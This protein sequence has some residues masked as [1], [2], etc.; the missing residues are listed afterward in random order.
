MR[1]LFFMAL[2]SVL[3]HSAFAEE[4]YPGY[5]WQALGSDIYLHAQN[6]PLAGPVDGNSVVIVNDDGVL[7][8]DTHINPAVARAVIGKI[9]SVTDAPVTHV[10]NTHWHDDH[11]NGNH[12]YR[13]TF[14]EVK[15][16]AHKDTLSSLKSQWAAMEDQRRAAYAEV[17]VEEL[18]RIA[19]R[20]DPEDPDSV[21]SYR[22]YAG[23]ITALRPELPNLRLEY[24]DVV[25]E[26][27]LPIEFSNRR[28]ELRWVGRGNTDG[29]IVVWLPGERILITGD[30][31]VAPIPFAFDS[32][33]VEWGATLRRLAEMQPRVLVP[34]HGTAQYDSYYLASVTALIEATTQRVKRAR[35]NGVTFEELNE[36]VDL[37]DFRS[38]F[39]GEDAERLW[40][41]KSYFVRP[42]VKSAWTSLGYPLP[43]E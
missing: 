1:R 40:A 9:R 5:V 32:P 37:A 16:M 36:A 21:I 18:L 17:D 24:P 8:V 3:I 28:I 22:V 7:V 10:I 6:D 34:G 11:T 4:I 14:P 12:A 31:L 35:E 19:S 29:D 2:M 20:P 13:Q 25:V 15:I 30:L 42:G 27:A 39:A 26:D 23:Y 41:W 43:E 33:M 38:K